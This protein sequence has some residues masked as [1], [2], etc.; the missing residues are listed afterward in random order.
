MSDVDGTYAGTAAGM[1]GESAAGE[2]SLGQFGPWFGESFRNAVSRAGHY[3]P[4]VLIFVLAISLPSSY[5]L[6]YAL[7]DTVLTIDP[8]TGVP[9][10]DYGGSQQ[11]LFVALASFPLTI[12][13]SFLLKG[14][15]MRQALAVKAEAPELWSDSVR[16]VLQRSSRVI[17]FSLLRTGFY[18]LL[19]TCLT[20]GAAAGPAAVLLVPV[21]GVAVAYLW[22]RF[23]FVGQVA[24]VGDETANPFAESWRLTGRSFWPLFGRLF[25][26]AAL[27]FNMILAAGIIGSP[28]TAIASGGA[29]ASIEPTADMIR[30]NDLMGPNPSVFALGSVFNALGLGANYVLVAVGT[31]LLYRNLG[32][33]F[34][35]A[36]EEPSIDGRVAE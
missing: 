2:G 27:A 35:L 11:W 26:L 33:R 19:F 3:L 7:R 24:A 21:V 31:T 29:T 30:F 28:F 36:V 25:I 22:V 12:V 17:G 5:A 16:A 9:D 13:L 8:D 23:A 32:G 15:A 20:L 34:S 18:L 14:A 4:M 6:W 1:T 10:L